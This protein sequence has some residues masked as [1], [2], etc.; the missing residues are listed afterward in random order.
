MEKYNNQRKVFVLDTSVLLYDARSIHSF[1]G[2]DIVLPLVVLDELDRKKE[3]PGL[4]GENARYVN[5]YLDSLLLS[6]I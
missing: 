6:L 4:V 5:R 2:N 1:P 3:K